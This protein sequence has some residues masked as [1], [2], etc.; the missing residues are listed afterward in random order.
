MSVHTD[1]KESVIH[2]PS[3]MTERPC[4]LATNERLAGIGAENSAKLVRSNT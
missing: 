4:A 3:P 2:R 1:K